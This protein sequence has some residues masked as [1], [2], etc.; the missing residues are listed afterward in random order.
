MSKDFSSNLD[1]PL[2]LRNNNPG[3][4][5]NGIAWLGGLPS[6]SGFIKFRDLSYGLRAL[7]VDLSNKISRDKLDTITKI[8][9]KYAPPSENNTVAYINAVSASSGFGKDEHITLSADA[10]MKLMRAII[11][12]EN[13]QNF[14]NLITNDDIKEGIEKM[15]DTIINLL[16]DFFA[17]N[18][19]IEAVAGVSLVALLVV[20]II[21]ILK[22]K[23]ISFDNFKNLIK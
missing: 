6:A 7:A 22:H 2:G 23:K 18:P 5:R 21:L 11:T 20:V 1:Y 8:I 9:S 4:L 13:G 3:N 14:A 16:Q 19:A 17:E 15:P 10:L 12:H